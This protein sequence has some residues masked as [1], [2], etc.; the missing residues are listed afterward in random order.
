MSPICRPYKIEKEIMEML[1]KNLDF[2]IYSLMAAIQHMF[3]LLLINSTNRNN[4]KIIPVSLTLF[5][6]ETHSRW[7]SK[8]LRNRSILFPAFC[9]V[10]VRYSKKFPPFPLN[11]DSSG[12][13]PLRQNFRKDRRD[14]MDGAKWFDFFYVRWQHKS[15]IPPN[16]ERLKLYRN[17]FI[18][19]I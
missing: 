2:L 16:I 15:R 7:I 18:F 19:H 11:R 1:K 8:S 3:W 4:G 9:A 14:D 12:S 17:S 6:H 13:L 10:A 5:F